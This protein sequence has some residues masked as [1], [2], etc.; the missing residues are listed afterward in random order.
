MA[1]SVKEVVVPT[2]TG[3]SGSRADKKG[4]D[5]LPLLPWSF[6]VL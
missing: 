4:G 1:H 5:P 2:A 6:L 3:S